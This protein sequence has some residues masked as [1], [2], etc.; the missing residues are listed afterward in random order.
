[1]SLIVLIALACFA[2][3]AFSQPV[4]PTDFRI[5][6]VARLSGNPT[7]LAF[8]PHGVLHVALLDERI[9]ALDA[10]PPRLVASGFQVLTGIAFLG[11]RLYISSR[12]QIAYIE[13]G[14]T[15]FIISGLPAG[16]H[17]NNSL[18]FGPDGTLY[19]GLGSTCNACNEPDPSKVTIMR[20]NP[21][22]SDLAA[23]TLGLR[24]SF[25]QGFHPATGDLFATDNGR[26]DLGAD[27]PPEELNR[28]VAGGHYGWPE[29]PP[30]PVEGSGTIPPVATFPAHSSANGMVFYN[31]RQFR[32]MEK[33]L[34]VGLFGNNPNQPFR[35]RNVVRVRLSKG[36]GGQCSASAENFITNM[37]NPLDLAVGPDEALYVADF[38]ARRIYRVSHADPELFSFR[39]ETVAAA[40][41][42]FAGI[43]L[44][45]PTT[46]ITQVGGTAIFNLSS[47]SQLAR[48][49]DGPVELETT[50]RDIHGIV[51]SGTE[52]GDSL[53]GYIVSGN[54]FP[55]L[56]FT[57]GNGNIHVANPG[58]AVANL[59]IESFAP[60]GS[61]LASNLRTLDGGAFDVV[62][63]SGKGFTSIRSDVGV[64]GVERVIEQSAAA[65]LSGVASV[66]STAYATH[67]FSGAGYA[68]RLKLIN[69]ST[70]SVNVT[71][72]GL[73]EPRESA[74]VPL[75]GSGFLKITSSAPVFGHIRIERPL[76][77]ALA[78][79]PLMYQPCGEWL[80]PH[81]ITGG[82]YF[83]GVA[84]VNPDGTAIDV[85]VEAFD[86]LRQRLGSSS[87]QIAGEAQTAQ[88]IEEFVPEA[89][90]R[91][92]GW[93]RIRSS[94]PI[95]VLGIY[96]DR[97]G[98]FLEAIEASSPCAR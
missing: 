26:D 65:A 27:E 42:R 44:A 7:S 24:N 1:M 63:V 56:V 59:Q 83:T 43:A 52:S 33:D 54:T 14:R 13:D 29:V 93:A 66:S 68:S 67:Y 38:G 96:G 62:T 97:E 48:L 86:S 21:D 75:A 85:T 94:Q 77:K 55:D 3:P 12:G 9:V 6:E 98:R 92:G 46:A 84:I 18:V 72:K 71:V 69:P 89:A 4:V 45:N 30:A 81:L 17:Q 95:L 74:E 36:A 76:E 80:L 64:S 19:F 90:G 41:G 57:G 8:S 88:L 11:N 79:V 60:D 2:R 82:L 49:V 78:L 47:G 73:L 5:A 50:N 35:E 39:A 23:H 15:V 53:D 16:N 10:D 40:N 91:L 32:G 31:S 61:I 70:G 22:G 25:D 58:T 20:A 28:I 87:Q 37:A 51:F 34:F